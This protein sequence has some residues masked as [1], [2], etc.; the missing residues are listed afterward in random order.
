[1]SG[2]DHH[3]IEVDTI[4][5]QWAS[6]NTAKIVK[7]YAQKGG[8]E[9]WAQ[10]EIAGV[11]TEHF[12]DLPQGTTKSV[13]NREVDVYPEVKTAKGTSQ[14]RA[15]VVV[16][17]KNNAGKLVQ[18]VIIELK[19]EG[20][21]NKDAFVKNVEADVAKVRGIIKDEYKPALMW[22]MGFSAS[23]E[24]YTEMKRTYPKGTSFEVYPLA[25]GPPVQLHPEDEA[26]KPR[27]VLW[28][29]EHELER[30][31]GDGGSTSSSQSQAQSQSANSVGPS[32]GQL[33]GGATAHIGLQALAMHSR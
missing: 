2:I 7:H 11:L 6:D 27:I 10:V 14:K 25:G 28:I 1:M 17:M 29:F 33:V 4:I 24:A 26:T 32:L 5:K 23:E 13:V 20:F 16:T 22:V 8:W 3:D 15:D 21:H 12:R 31:I 18:A 9:G 19:C 30:V